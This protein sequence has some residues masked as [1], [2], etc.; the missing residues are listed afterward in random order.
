MALIVF[1]IPM[2]ECGIYKVQ[3]VLT[4]MDDLDQHVYWVL[5]MEGPSVYGLL[6]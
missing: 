4:N 1:L 2:L 5:G 3:E 6:G